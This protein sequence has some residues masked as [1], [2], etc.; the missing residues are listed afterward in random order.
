MAVT[1]DQVAALHALLRGD[2]SGYEELYA[3]LGKS[4]G[5]DY[6]A[7]IGAAFIIAAE[8]R[9]QAGSTT[10]DVIQFVADARSHDPSIAESIDQNTAERLVLAALT[11]APIDDIDAKTATTT[12]LLLLA[13]MTAAEDFRA[14]DLDS[15]MEEARALLSE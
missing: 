7:L 8:R 4:D 10:A 14:A 9:F 2:R 12:E 13:A 1:D 6:A 11:D 15:L 3:K 5:R